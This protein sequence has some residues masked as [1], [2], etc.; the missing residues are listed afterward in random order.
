MRLKLSE[1]APLPASS[2]PKHSVP[3]S[4][5]SFALR[6]RKARVSA[7]KLARRSPSPSPPPPPPVIQEEDIVQ[8]TL[9]EDISPPL[10][11]IDDHGNVHDES[12]AIFSSPTLEVEEVKGNAVELTQEEDTSLADT[13]APSMDVEIMASPEPIQSFS[14]EESREMKQSFSPEK[15]YVREY[16]KYLKDHDSIARIEQS[17]SSKEAK[18]RRIMDENLSKIGVW[19]NSIDAIEGLSD[20]QQNKKTEDWVRK[21]DLLVSRYADAPSF[22]YDEVCWLFA[23]KLFVKMKD[24]GDTIGVRTKS[25]ASVIVRLLFAIMGH[26]KQIM[27]DLVYFFLSYMF[28]KIPYLSVY[29]PLESIS[30]SAPSEMRAFDGPVRGFCLFIA[31]D[32]TLLY[33]YSWRWLSGLLNISRPCEF[34]FGCLDAS[35]AFETVASLQSMYGRQAGKLVSRIRALASDRLQD[36]KPETRMR[37]RSILQ[38]LQ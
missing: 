37:C 20:Y 19:F 30:Y 6:S 4:R 1:H 12:E 9:I 7:L 38:H 25:E 24:L 21:L 10:S 15:K 5:S 2:G 3:S 18:K 23:Q 33:D 31:R 34:V 8:P 29:Q 22:Q 26:G 17:C 13:S 28:Y 27:R 14:K 11:P 16:D 32:R 36:P 35:L